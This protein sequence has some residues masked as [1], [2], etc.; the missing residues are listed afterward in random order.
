MSAVRTKKASDGLKKGLSEHVSEFVRHCLS[1]SM[2]EY[3]S[4]PDRVTQHIPHTC[5]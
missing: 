1:V 3:M 5:H 2:R 4:D